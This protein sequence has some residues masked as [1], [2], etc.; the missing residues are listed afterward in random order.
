MKP[1]AGSRLRGSLIV[2]ADVGG[3]KASVIISYADTATVKRAVTV[4]SIEWYRTGLQAVAE[5]LAAALDD[6]ERDEVS[7][8]VVGA[9]GCDTREQCHRLER[10][11]GT[12]LGVPVL[13]LNDAELVLPAAGAVSGIGLISGTGSIA[14]GYD[15]DGRLI[16]AGGWGGFIGDEGSATGLFR[17]SARA[18]VLAY[19]RGDQEDPLSTALLELLDLAD[20]RD[21]PARLATDVPPTAWA[22]LAPPVLER[23]LSAGSSLAS[24]VVDES[25]AALADLVVVLGERGGDTTVVVAAGGLVTNAEWMRSA[26]LRVFSERLPASRI[27]FLDAEPVL[28]AVRLGI[29]FAGLLAGR[30]PSHGLHPRLRESLLSLGPV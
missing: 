15:R 26:L 2:G 27:S 29:D 9:H 16:A 18:A 17:D 10:A 3:S 1:A 13:A 4:P 5:G 25:A 6:G 12:I 20:L 24:R 11:L 22:V 28:G 14:V 23:A 7:T 21:L 30:E 19:D 8:V